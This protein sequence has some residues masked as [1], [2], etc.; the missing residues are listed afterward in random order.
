VR[1]QYL[2]GASSS[3]GFFDQH[4]HSSTSRNVTYQHVTESAVLAS[5]YRAAR[6]PAGL[7]E[8]SVKPGVEAGGPPA[9]NQPS[10]TTF[11][12]GMSR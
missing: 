7:P 9:V 1:A 6:R 11:V 5:E 2:R 12:T 8:N 10:G 3:G 4:S